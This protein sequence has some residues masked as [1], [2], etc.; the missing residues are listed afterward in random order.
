MDTTSPGDMPPEEFRA[1]SREVGEWIADY[2]ESVEGYPVLANVRPGEIRGRLSGVPPADGERFEEIF[3]DFKDL[4]LPGITH[5]NHPGFQAYFASTGSGPGILGEFLAAALNVNAMVWRSSP[6]GTELEEHVLD[7]TRKLLGLPEGFVGA[8]QDTASTSTLVALSAARQRLFPEV[9]DQGLFGV[10]RAR[11]YASEEAHSS[12]EKAAIMLGL[13][14]SGIRRIPVDRQFRA[15]PDALDLAIREDLDQGV[16]PMAVVATVGTTSTSSVDPVGPIA[17]ITRQLGLWLHVDAAY[18]GVSA[19][20]PELRGHFEGWEMA[21]SVV[22]N[23]H[24][25]LFTPVDCSVLLTRVPEELKGALALTPEY[26][27]TAEDGSATNLMDYGIALGRRFRALKLWFVLR[28]FGA[29]GLRRR[30]REHIRIANAFA[31]WV[32]REPAWETLAP[33]PFSTV[34]FRYASA[35]Q[36]GPEQ[37][38]QNLAILERVNASGGVFISHTRLRSRVALRLTV[39]NLRTTE[40]HVRRTWSILREAGQQVVSAA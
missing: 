36:S 10:S 38:T 2:L 19:I 7:W 1:S 28:Y 3:E 13:G 33:V 22:F 17:E 32:D 25:W 40:E 9:R 27:T 20:L 6:A 15:L 31:T 21:D 11:I 37:D 26:L 8:I 4:I 14:R 30:I 29:E 39:G 35:G 5:W 18:A 23:P 12:V 24:K 16:Q 34:A